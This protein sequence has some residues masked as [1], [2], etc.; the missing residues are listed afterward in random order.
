MSFAFSPSAQIEHKAS[1]L[2]FDVIE[3]NFYSGTLADIYGMDVL[4]FHFHFRF[5]LQH[6]TKDGVHWNAIAHR[7]MT[8]LLLRHTAEAWGVIMPCQ[9]KAIGEEKHCTHSHTETS[10]PTVSQYMLTFRRTAVL[11]CSFSL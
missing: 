1:H 9:Q 5:S 3:A 2:R 6:R 4:D 7:R 10:T 11:G 8:S